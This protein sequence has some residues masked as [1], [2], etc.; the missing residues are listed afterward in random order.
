MGRSAPPPPIRTRLIAE[1]LAF[2]QAASHVPGVTRIAL[3]GS[4]TTNKPDPKDADLL[5]TVTD[6][7]DL[8]ALAALGRKLQGHAQGFNCGGEVFLSDPDGTYL[9]RTCP[10][11]QCAQGIRMSCDAR[12]C[13]WRP[14]LHDDL[15]AIVL[16]ERLV[17]AP[18][19]ELWPRIG[20][21]VPLPKDIA[22]G[23]IV[24]L[25]EAHGYQLA[26][27]QALTLRPSP[28]LQERVSELLYRSKEG[29]LTQQEA[30]ELERYLMLDHLVRLAKAHA[31]RH[32]ADRLEP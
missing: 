12:H 1:V 28:E 4:L 30:T 32:A 16:H 20:A 3:I 18:P 24:P 26:P 27:A 5:V 10:W 11:R 19:I 29:E 31:A 14:Y 17:V 21:R 8:A 9:G 22:E 23:L 25:G 13:G 2:V 6:D 7:A 15:D